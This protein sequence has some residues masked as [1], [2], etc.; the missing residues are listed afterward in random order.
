V[1]PGTNVAVTFAKL[2]PV[3]GRVAWVAGDSFG[4]QFEPTLLDAAELLKL[5]ALQP[6]A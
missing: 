1:K 4:V 3:K 6:A 5:I 2:R